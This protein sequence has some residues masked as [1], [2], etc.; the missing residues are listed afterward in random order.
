MNVVRN[1]A[2]G[3]VLAIALT[4]AAVSAPPQAQEVVPQYSGPANHNVL[5]T[6]GLNVQSQTAGLAQ[7]YVKAEKDDEKKEIRKKLTDV[8]G[9]QFNAQ[10]QRQQKDLED[11]EKQIASL[12][13]VLKK[14]QDAKSTIVERRVE[15]LIQEAEGLG[16]TAPSTPHANT[17]YN[18]FFD[19]TYRP[20][21]APR[22]R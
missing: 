13:A 10:V 15:Q 4:C 21:A 7:Q 9:Q 18:R 8:L 1:W 14:R 6:D 3:L 20:D 5:L 16:W 12:R 19:P 2:I 22:Q 17:P 11:L